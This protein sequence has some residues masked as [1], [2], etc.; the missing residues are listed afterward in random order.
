MIKRKLAVL[1]TGVLL[2]SVLSGC[3]ST[4]N[5]VESFTH[6][7]GREG[8]IISTIGIVPTSGLPPWW[9]KVERS[10]CEAITQS[11]NVECLG[12]SQY[13]ADP[14]MTFWE[15]GEVLFYEG[16]DAILAVRVKGDTS[17]M[18]HLGYSVSGTSTTIG[19]VRH[20]QG[21]AT[22]MNMPNR[23]LSFGYHLHYI[24]GYGDSVSLWEATLDQRGLGFLNTG[25]DTLLRSAS[26]RLNQEISPWLSQ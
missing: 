3:S 8:H 25:D 6:P 10:H 2:L 1:I 20:H 14:E 23:T 4:P 15:R 21:T 16:A 13:A 22:P 11:A 7:A 19:N 5:R 9:Q 18:T 24:L 26:R 17:G 12:L